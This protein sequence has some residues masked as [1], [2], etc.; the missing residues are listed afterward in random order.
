MI[1]LGAVAFSS[2]DI[3]VPAFLKRGP[4]NV[5]PFAL[6]AA[7]IDQ[8]LITSRAFAPSEIAFSDIPKSNSVKCE[9]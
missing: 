7:D 4:D 5:P 8:N 3:A 9:A 2:D 6:R 1:P